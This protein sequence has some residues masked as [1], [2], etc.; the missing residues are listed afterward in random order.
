MNLEMQRNSFSRV[1]VVE[2]GI[3]RGKSIV[4]VTVCF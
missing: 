2:E 3:F 4:H 1:V